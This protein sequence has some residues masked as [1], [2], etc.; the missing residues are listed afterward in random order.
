[1]AAQS[2]VLLAVNEIDLIGKSSRYMDTTE[3]FSSKVDYR[4][5]EQRSFKPISRWELN[6]LLL[7]IITIALQCVWV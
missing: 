2:T 3:T 5:P 1:M 7:N 4:I 6:V